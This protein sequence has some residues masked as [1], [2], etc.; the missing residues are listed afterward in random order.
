M[1]TATAVATEIVVPIDDSWTSRRSLSPAVALAKRLGVP[2][3]LATVVRPGSSGGSVADYLDWL[4]GELRA[5]HPGLELDETRLEGT[6]VADTLLDRIPQ[7]AVLCVATD[8]ASNEHPDMTHSDALAIV[9]RATHPVLLVGGSVRYEPPTGRTVAPFDG[10]EASAAA[11]TAAA[12]WARALGVDLVVSQVVTPGDW[13]RFEERRAAGEQGVESKAVRELADGIGAGWEI[14]HAADHGSGTLSLIETV[15][16]GLVV[17]T[18]D[19]DGAGADGPSK[20]VL[21][22]LQHAPCPTL[23]IPTTT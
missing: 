13:A 15:R 5:A 17:T 7:T 20:A 10:S 14:V 23:L 6:N 18:P 22:I 21:E 19:L 3:R 4:I 12:P 9:A 1:V 11:A 16:A 8:R 2:I